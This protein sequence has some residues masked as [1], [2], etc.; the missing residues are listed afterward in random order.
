[1]DSKKYRHSALSAAIASVLAI[2]GTT[3]TSPSAFAKGPPLPSESQ[4][5]SRN[6]SDAIIGTG[7]TDAI[8]GTGV[9]DAIIGTGVTDAI[10]GTGVTDAIIGTG[11][12]DAII[13]TGVTD[14][15][16]GTGVHDSKNNK[17]DPDHSRIVALRG[18]VEKIDQ[19]NSSIT[20]YG[21]QFALDPSTEL[22]QL[23]LSEIS[24]GQTF[25]VEVLTEA[26]DL[27]KLKKAVMRPVSDMHVPGVSKVVVTGQISSVDTL[28]GTAKIEGVTFDYSAILS[29]HPVS[30]DVGDLVQVVGTQ[31]QTGGMV[32]VGQIKT[33]VK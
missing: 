33:F 13:G 6:A 16:I 10:I 15:I 20:V 1:M 27:Q 32:L 4:S 19:E 14:A 9:T 3:A 7:V 29:A 11:V 17:K 24:A 2:A 21:R 23:A 22:F 28:S 18:P 25:D 30:L 5:I 8:I 26:N 31:P 12:T